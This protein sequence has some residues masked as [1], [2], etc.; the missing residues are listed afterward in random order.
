MKTRKETIGK[1]IAFAPLLF[2]FVTLITVL[3]VRGQLQYYSV[4]EIV[5]RLVRLIV[6]FSIPVIVFGVLLVVL[7]VVLWCL[8]KHNLKKYGPICGEAKF[9][10]KEE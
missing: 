5:D 10:E 2:F 7:R 3:R 1:Y 9:H 6:I 8:G 4:D